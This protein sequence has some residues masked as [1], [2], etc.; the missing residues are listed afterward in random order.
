[1]E[2]SFL[3]HTNEDREYIKKE[4]GIKDIN[5]LFKDIPADALLK[6]KLPL[7][8]SISEEETLALL[9]EYASMNKSFD[10]QSLFIG[11]GIYDI[12]VPAMVK[13][14]ATR[15]EFFTAYTPYQ[16]EVSQG[17]LQIIY[18][19]QTMISNLTGMD[20]SNASMYDGATSLAESILMAMR[21]TRRYE[22]ILIN[23]INPNYK[24]VIKTYTQGMG[25]VKGVEIDFSIEELKKH[26]NEKIACVVV[27]NPD[28]LGRLKDLDGFA[29]LIHDNG[30]L[31]IV[32]PYYPALAI[33]KSPGSYGADIVCGEGQSLGLNMYSGGP[34]LGLLSAK[35]EF[36]RMMPGRIIAKTIDKDEKTAY[37]MTL[38]TREQ[39]IKR[40][41]ATSNICSNEG[42]CLLMSAVY[43]SMIGEEGL[44]KIATNSME[45]AHYL[46]D[47]LIKIDGIEAK[48]PNEY[49][50]NE[51][52][53]RLSINAKEFINK[54]HDYGIVAGIDLSQFDMEQN[55]VLVAVTEKRKIE[56]LNLYIEKAKQIL[57]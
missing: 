52:T 24:K 22:Y 38:Q 5:E 39:H 28:F 30:S 20:I 8:D 19:H 37:V 17:T 16:P 42:L 9:T 18:E 56:E 27:Q 46:F 32:V 14:I 45:K 53:L 47:E 26:L 31:F 3:P 49:F 4:I 15:P 29:D 43:L 2:Y 21:K 51:F 41:K 11:G 10:K 36:V 13:H 40:E 50:F 7:P 54:M 6:D 25:D 57:T 35:K 12:Y 44:K 48:Y 33:L 1:M 23:E 34:L 55:E